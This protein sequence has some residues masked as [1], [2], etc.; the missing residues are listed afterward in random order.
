MPPYHIACSVDD[1][2]PEVRVTQ[3][4]TD[5]EVRLESGKLHWEGIRSRKES[6]MNREKKEKNKQKQEKKPLVSRP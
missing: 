5:K 3:S 6:G 2:I 4:E 1:D